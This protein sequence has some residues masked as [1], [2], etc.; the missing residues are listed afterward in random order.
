MNVTVDNNLIKIAETVKA[1]ID[2]LEL[3]SSPNEPGRDE[4]I[5]HSLKL[6]FEG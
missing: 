3:I 2:S 1:K 5:M 6:I 4:I